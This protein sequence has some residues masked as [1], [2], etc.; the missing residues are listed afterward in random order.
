[1]VVEAQ[2][3]P[4]LAQ[5]VVDCIR[6]VTDKP[7]SRAVALCEATLTFGKADEPPPSLAR[8]M[9]A[10]LVSDVL[11][12]ERLATTGAVD[13]LTDVPPSLTIRDHL[14]QAFQAGSRKGGSGLGLAIAAELIRGH[15]GTLD[16]V[17]S[18]SDGTEFMLHLPR[19]LAAGEQAA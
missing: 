8:F 19:E 12:G 3:T 13:F 5:K 14:F 10:G 6:T 16:L 15:G 7:I 11:D 4:R 17:R 9:L 18:D 2:S 1:M